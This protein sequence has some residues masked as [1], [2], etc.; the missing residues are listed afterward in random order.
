MIM[1]TRPAPTTSQRLRRLAEVSAETPEEIRTAIPA[2][3]QRL[4][5]EGGGKLTPEILKEAD[6]FYD[7]DVPGCRTGIADALGISVYELRK[8][9][10]RNRQV[11][12]K[13]CETVF[14]VF[15]ARVRGGYKPSSQTLCKK[16]ASRAAREGSAKW[17]K[18]VETLTLEHNC[19]IEV[20]LAILDALKE[21]QDPLIVEPLRTHLLRLALFWIAGG[22]IG[23]THRLPGGYRLGC[24][25]MIC[26]GQPVHLLILD[27]KWGKS[28]PKD[29][30]LWQ[31]L[32]RETDYAEPMW[33]RSN[34]PEDYIP[35]PPLTEIYQALWRMPE[36]K[37]WREIPLIPVQHS[38]IIVACD[39]CRQVFAHSHSEVDL[40]EV[41]IK[42]RGDTIL[43]QA[44]GVEKTLYRSTRK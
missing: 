14:T 32:R 1:N 6:Q 43:V 22:V 29:S 25:C 4:V 7:L 40:G 17:R 35:W 12:C 15:E 18:Q 10:G 28:I 42:D 26:S 37:Y 23:F 11:A 13:T 5:Q 3:F 38:P 2:Y 39:Y 20:E 31:A 34:P 16:C 19:Q 9:L 21:G 41:S 30:D 8:A 24:G 36:D 27:P 33:A 44:A